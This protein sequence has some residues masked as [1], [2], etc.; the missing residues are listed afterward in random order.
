MKRFIGI[1]LIFILIFSQMTTVGLATSNPVNVTFE[2]DEPII[3]VGKTFKLTLTISKEE[4][5]DIEI[6]EV[7]IKSSS[8]FVLT[9][10]AFRKPV[11]DNQVSF[12]F[13]Y[14][15]GSDF[16]IPI[17]VYTDIGTYSYSIDLPNVDS[18]VPEEPDP[19]DEDEIKPNITIISSRTTSA[20]AGESERIPITIKNSSNHNAYD[21]AVT[22][23]IDNDAPITITGEGY[24]SISR[25]GDGREEDI[26]FRIR[27]DDYA[28]NGT[29]PIKVNFQYFNEYDISFTNTETIYVKIE[30]QNTKPFLS[31][32]RI[33]VIPKQ[34]IAGEQ[35]MVGFELENNG[36]LE[37]KDIKISLEGISNDTF[38]ISSG[39]NSKYVKSIPGGQ[40]E[41]VYFYI[42]ASP[43]LAGGT[44]SLDVAL[45]YKDGINQQYN[46]SNKFFID[47]SSNKDRISNLIIENISYPEGSVGQNQDVTVSFDLKNMGKLDSRNITVKA[48]SIDQNG[49]V[50]KSVSIKKI[51]TIAPNKSTKMNFV[52]LATEDAETK[53]YPINIT[54]EY[55]DDLS[56]NNEKHTLTQYVGVYVTEPGE[57]GKPKLIIDKYSFEPNIVKAGENFVMNLSFFNTNGQ[58]AIRNIKIFLT[59]NE[60][61]DPDSHSSGSSVFTPVDSSNT[62]YID[63]IS[64]KSRVEKSITM[65]TVPDAQAK[66]YTLTAN[67][68]YENSDGE[69]FIATELIGVPVVQQ[70][71]L[72]IGELNLPPEAFIG[73]PTPVY[74]DFFNTGKVSLYNMMV[75]LEGDFQTENG[76]FYVGNF[77]MGRSEY[78]EGMVIPT[79]PGELTGSIVFTYETS[80]GETV[81]ERKEF[82]M[83]VMEQMPMDEFPE[84][85]P[86]M[87][88][89]NSSIFKKPIFWILIVLALGA[90]G[91]V[92]Y[93]K[94]KKKG[95]ALDE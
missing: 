86:P 77:E 1:I 34:S 49:L 52:F 45:D 19:I 85:M 79:Q 88:N 25:L 44:H 89:E 74:V 90:G 66:T 93:K 13:K 12:R 14:N 67:F 64:P 92:F 63:S 35:T 39:L 29:Y 37:A 4:G 50:P 3:E 32:S 9:D 21:I 58:Q 80:S 55:E 57:L 7:G 81:E 18:S 95:M 78:F 47:V 17:T 69:E 42:V 41:Y 53:N 6:N 70:S 87:E 30:N 65:F 10:S 15:G 73:Q 26:N 51:N 11:Y 76:S 61:T 16:T 83:N 54:V 48:E 38:A 56:E 36:T 33:D 91:L 72:E 2:T 60:T 68:E 46:D 43:K 75:K 28:K 31:I 94:R 5:N 62:F 23:E 8:S 24:E 27:V 59:A 20:E 71:E 40:S 82:T 22:P 84:E